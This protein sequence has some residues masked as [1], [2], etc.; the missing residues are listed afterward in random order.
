M[1]SALLTSTFRTS[2]A[3]TILNNIQYGKSKYFHFIGRVV[4]WGPSSDIPPTNIVDTL[5]SLSGVRNEIV[6]AKRVDYTDVSIVIDRIDWT[7]GTSYAMWD[8]SISMLGLNFYVLTLD[9]RVYKCLNNNSGALSTVKPTSTSSLPVVTS[10]GYL[11]KYMYTLGNTKIAKFLTNMSVPVQQAIS[12]RFY[13]NG[14]ISGIIVT[15][16]GS[17][18]ISNASTTL[19]AAGGTGAI[20]IPTISAAGGISR[21]TIVNG[22]T[23][24]VD[25]CVISIT[26]IGTGLYGASATF[27]AYVASGV[28]VY[29]AVMDPGRNYL[30]DSGS[31]ITIVGD[32]T[33]ASFSPVIYNGR[34]VDVMVNS[35]GSGYT[36]ANAYVISSLGTGAALGVILAGSDFVSDQSTI[37][38]TAING[39]IHAV[40]MVTPGESYTTASVAIVGDGTGCIATATIVSGSI[41]KIN[42]TAIGAGYTYA[43]AII[44][45]NNISNNP[46][47]TSATA[48][49]MLSPLGGHGSN[50][51]EE[52]FGRTLAISSNLRGSL[53]PS[54]TQDFRQYGLAVGFKDYFTNSEIYTKSTVKGYVSAVFNNS[55]GLVIDEILNGV[56]GQFRVLSF[57]G[58][59]INLVPLTNPTI[60]PVGT[61]VAATN[62][63]RSYN[64][65]AR[66]VSPD[67]NKYSGT[68][69]YYSDDPAFTYSDEQSVIIKT[70]IKF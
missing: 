40:K 2:I 70:F 27:R 35:S 41:S 49:V 19:S 38:Q 24:Y 28:I 46:Y 26:G 20:L 12:D 5:E 10:D 34:V 48:K 29:V 36:Y 23:G 8:S 7:S 6:L 44:T 13:N 66:T 32:G 18:Y 33:G 3:S 25:N 54:I 11:W 30:S 16:P 52:L 57:S 39:A 9:N 68:I 47:A 61:L 17:N 50:A 55:T 69:I 63:S 45:G 67:F 37:E 21:V 56:G 22:G 43:N 1:A 31:S 4:P 64:C 58:S 42:I 14:S 53:D 65:T 60:S 51:T 62:S 59:N 15:A